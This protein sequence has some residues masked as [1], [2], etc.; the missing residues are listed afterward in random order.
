MWY[1]GNANLRLSN[2]IVITNH[3]CRH[4]YEHESVLIDAATQMIGKMRSGNST[5]K[6]VFSFDVAEKNAVLF[7]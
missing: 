4:R 6:A 5:V 7:Y 1:L 2:S 3:P